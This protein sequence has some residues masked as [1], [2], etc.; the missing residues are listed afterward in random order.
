MEV[1]EEIEHIPYGDEITSFQDAL[2]GNSA[3]FERKLERVWFELFVCPVIFQKP[4]SPLRCWTEKMK[5]EGRRVGRGLKLPTSII[6][7]LVVISG[8][9]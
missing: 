2:K 6:G 8:C 5:Q 9:W 4:Y 7:F 1:A 3:N